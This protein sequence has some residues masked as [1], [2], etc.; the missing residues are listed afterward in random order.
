[1]DAKYVISAV[2]SRYEILLRNHINESHHMLRRT[3]ITQ[4]LDGDRVEGTI[5]TTIIC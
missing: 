1:M 4:N 2:V 3:I 5:N